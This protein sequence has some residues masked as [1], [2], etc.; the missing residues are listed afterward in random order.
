[1]VRDDVP[2]DQLLFGDIVYV[3][4][5]AA[6]PVT[7]SQTDNNHYVELQRN[8]VDLSNPANLVRQTQ[9]SL[10]GTPLGATQTAGIMTTRGFAS[11]F[12]GRRNESS[13]RALRGAE[14]AVHGHGGLPR[15]HGVAGSHSAGRQPL[16]GRR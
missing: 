14:L 15:R 5:T 13:R 1:M 3:G 11:A 7:Y 6:T 4:S 16:A 9:S 2:F 12:L 10:P 8:R